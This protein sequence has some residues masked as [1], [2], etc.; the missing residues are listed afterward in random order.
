MTGVLLLFLEEKQYRSKSSLAGMMEKTGLPG[1][2][3]PGQE[4]IRGKLHES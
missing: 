1:G 4:L 2:A 3:A